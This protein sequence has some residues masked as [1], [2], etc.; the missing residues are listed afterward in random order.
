MQLSAQLDP[1]KDL[2]LSI[3]N[4]TDEILLYNMIKNAIESL[5]EDEKKQIQDLNK[6]FV[7]L[8]FD[9]VEFARKC[10]NLWKIEIEALVR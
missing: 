10:E 1:Y 9:S 8:K 6:L 3:G 7:N 4:D 2:V 5:T